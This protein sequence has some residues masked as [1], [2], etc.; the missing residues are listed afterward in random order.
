LSA[1][2]SPF[3]RG[4]VIGMLLVG[5][6]AFVALLWFLGN[7]TGGS[8]ND[9]GAHVGGKGLNGFVGLAQML[10]SEGLDVQRLRNRQTI[11]N[12]PGLLILTPPAG[13]EGKEIAK[14]VD[15]RR[16]IGP[17]LVIAPKWFAT[18]VQSTK[19]KQGWVQILST[20][21]PEWPG[22]ADNVTVEI[23]D[24]KSAPAGGW[25]VDGRRGK[26]PDDRQV[27]YGSGKGLVPIVNAG[28]GKILAAW[29]DDDGY[30]PGLN[31]LAGIDPDYGGEDEDIYPVVMVFEPDLM[32]NWGLADK[33]TAL[34]ARD[35][36]LAT[37]DD[38]D[39]PIAFDMTLNG[40]SASRN[41]LTLAFEPPFLAATICLLLAALAVAWRALHRFGPAL[42]Q[43]P[44]IALGK[45]A[46]V[47][48]AAG[49]IRRAGR[50]HL[51]AAPYADAVRERIALA[52]GLPRGL[53]HDEIERL[54]DA[55]QERRG[56]PGPTFS[57]AARHL[58]DARK[59]HDVTRRA[60]VLQQIERLLK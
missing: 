27:E 60:L 20:T 21:A 13:A 14:I 28:N 49:L 59:P 57:S 54:I 30:Y 43:G 52:L 50:V 7:N 26:L 18:G 16:Y 45:A 46:L 58:R 2:P 51:A 23:G 19:A 5:A 53:S 1:A 8:G 10:E 3:S 37:A 34:L 39:M 4:T 32:D 36:V 22:F 55:A 56:V 42:S 11:E 9:G 17:T 44:E 24:K 12:T 40:F 29:L 38:R 15:A 41:L 33:A 31:A 47:G 48:N 35:L 25:R 6:L